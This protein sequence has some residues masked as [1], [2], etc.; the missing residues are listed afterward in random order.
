VGLDRYKKMRRF[1]ETP[2]PSGGAS[3]DGA[4]IFVVQLHHASHR[5][6][7][8]RL[9]HD[10]VLKSWAVPKGPSF[11]P[12]V[13]RLA[14]QVEDHPLDYATFEGRIPAGNYGAGDVLIFDHGTWSTNES[15]RHQLAKGHLRFA[16]HGD[17]LRGEWDLVRTGD[18]GGKPR[19]LL[20]KTDDE[21]AGP[22]ESDDLL[23]DPEEQRKP[24]AV[25]VSRRKK[26]GTPNPDATPTTK[27]RRNGRRSARATATPEPRL[28]HGERVV[29]PEHG[30]TKGDVFAYYRAVAPFLLPQIAGRPLALVRAPDGAAGTSF[31][32]KHLSPGFGEGVH[33]VARGDKGDPYVWVEDLAGLLGLAQ[34]NVLEIHAW[35]GRIDDLAN[36]DRI[37]I[38]LDPADDVPWKKVVT[39]AELVRDTLEGAG[40][41]SFARVTGGKGIHVVAPLSPG[42]PWDTAKDFTHALASALTRARP[43]EFIEVM[44]KSK[45]TGK[46]FVDYLRNGRGA[47]AIASYSLRNKPAATVAM[48]VRWDEL[49]KLPGADAYDLPSALQHLARR[50]RDPWAGM[51]ELEQALPRIS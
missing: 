35:G 25:W 41:Q 46:I 12:K 45:R 26:D 44:T 38:D 6:Y 51:D 15:V 24:T 8:F 27:P 48:P 36:A 1:G 16:L 13:N 32:Q 28:T 43:D 23:G 7:D 50:K 17:K 42:A 31:F 5:H 39:A 47:T 29:Y 14:M 9:E 19:W 40:L 33:G 18:E 10:G 11:D 34:M 3:T 30:L 2:E 4:P 22:F 21:E 49:R 20:R 37:V